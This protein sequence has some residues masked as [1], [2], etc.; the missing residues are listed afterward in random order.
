MVKT[1]ME[2]CN[3]IHHLPEY[4]DIIIF[5]TNETMLQCIHT[6]DPDWKDSAKRI[7]PRTYKVAQLMGIID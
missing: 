3:A 6:L 7:E 4:K 2:I 5:L 1:N